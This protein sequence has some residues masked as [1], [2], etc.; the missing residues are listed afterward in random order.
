MEIIITDN[1]RLM[2][3]A[4]TRLVV[5]QI[6]KNQDTVLALAT[7]Q[8][9]LGLYENLAGAAERKEVSFRRTRIFLLDEY[10]GLAKTA[11]QSFC[12]L[13]TRRLFKRLDVE[14]ENIFVL[15]GQ[16]EN[17]RQECARYE[18]L[19]KEHGGIDLLILGIGLDGHIAFNEPGSDFNS[20]TRVVKLTEQTR[21]SNVKNFVSLRQVPHQGITMG[22]ATIMKAGKIVLMAAG[23]RKAKIVGRALKGKISKAVPASILQRHRDFTVV[24]DKAAAQELAAGGKREEKV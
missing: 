11:S 24:L 3:A 2:S 8:T 16:A 22:L 21:R 17:L 14:Q 18:A 7:G 1:Y 6:K 13:M 9:Q 15:N 23:E 19:I 5:K 12:R 20:K 10:V 4:A